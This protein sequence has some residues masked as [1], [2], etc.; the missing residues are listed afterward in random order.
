MKVPH[1]SA[2]PK[3]L[4]TGLAKPAQ[5]ALMAA[6]IKNLAQL[7]AFSRQEIAI[8]HGIRP[9]ALD[10]LEHALAKVELS[11]KPDSTAD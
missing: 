3:E 1:S 4:P 6:G 7:S 8:L 10:T 9:N 5:S 11:F 2:I